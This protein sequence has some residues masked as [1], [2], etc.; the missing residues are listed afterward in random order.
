MLYVIY[1]ILIFYLRIIKTIR[2]IAWNKNKKN[3][4]QINVI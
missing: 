2:L 3:N 1:A 4:A